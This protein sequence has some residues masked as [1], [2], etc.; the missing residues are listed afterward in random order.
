MGTYTGKK[1]ATGYSI[2]FHPFTNAFNFFISINLPELKSDVNKN[3]CI[4]HHLIH[5][6]IQ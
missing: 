1:Y 3:I 4:L 5:V 2:L 6:F